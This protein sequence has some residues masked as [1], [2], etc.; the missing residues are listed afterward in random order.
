MVQIGYRMAPKAALAFASANGGEVGFAN[1]IRGLA[2]IAGFTLS[3][4]TF[5]ADTICDDV[6][7]TDEPVYEDGIIAQGV[8]DA[9]AAGVAYFSSAGNNIGTN[10]YEGAFKYVPYTGG[11]TAAD[12]PAQMTS[13]LQRSTFPH[14]LD[15]NYAIGV[16]RVAGTSAGKVTRAA[17]DRRKTFRRSPRDLRQKS[18]DFADFR[19]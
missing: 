19:S 12:S 3:G 11:T 14:D 15:P 7:Y 17:A 13:I 2:G 18:A 8:E 6:T 1:N 9:S 5:A 10:T 4:Q 16:A